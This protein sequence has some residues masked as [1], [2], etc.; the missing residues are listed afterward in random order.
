MDYYYLQRRYEGRL[1]LGLVDTKLMD[2]R[3]F[4]WMASM[5]FSLTSNSAVVTA[6]RLNSGHSHLSA[7]AQ[8]T[9]LRHPRLQANYDGEFDLTEAA[10]I[11]RRNDLRAGTVSL[12]G[13]GD[14]SFD[15]FA[16]NG[17]VGVENLAFENSQVAVSRASANSNYSISDQQVKFSKL[18]GKVFGG[19]FTGD[20][21]FN[22]WLA[23]QQHLS[24]VARKNLD[25]AVISAAHPSNKPAEKSRTS[26][27]LA[28][29]TASIILHLRDLSAQD[30]TAAI[31][32]TAHPASRFHPAALASGT[33]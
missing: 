24:A 25:T 15:Q 20:A 22:Q 31:R 19:S 17:F 30:V 32:S 29:Q 23:P 33:I 18:Q 14:W 26:K 3:P 4:A 9:D 6:F 13:H 8:V 11:A 1:L 16:A 10:S 5:G 27:P 21:E 2:C 12:K 7:Q 28:I